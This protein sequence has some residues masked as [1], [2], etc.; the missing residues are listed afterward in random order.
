MA[1]Y[2]NYSLFVDVVNGVASTSF[3]DVKPTNN[4]AFY[5]ADNSQLNIYFV[6]PNNNSPFPYEEVDTS[7]VDNLLVTLGTATVTATAFSAL[8]PLS[9]AA[10][11]VT[12]VVS[13]SAGVN[14]VMRISIGPEP[15]G[16]SFSINY[17]GTLLDPTSVF[18]SAA[19]IYNQFIDELSITPGSISV[20]KTGNFTWDITFGQTFAPPG[21]LTVN[22]GGIVS[23]TGFLA[24]LDL[25]A[26]GVATLLGTS[27]SA[28]ATL[29][30]ATTNTSGL[31]KQTACQ[32]DAT[33]YQDIL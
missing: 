2:T 12:T 23:F 7:G 21:S 8:I 13:Y 33:V 4:L 16:G 31:L 25:T 1:L 9:A 11:T 17:D 15:K 32:I 28:A 10:S 22:D 30:I 3:Q 5:N 20:E 26:A 14:Q 29:E 18:A 24:V 27:T 6:R 19:D